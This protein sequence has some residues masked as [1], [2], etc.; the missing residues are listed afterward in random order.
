MAEAPESEPVPSASTE[1]EI[2]AAPPD[3]KNEEGPLPEKRRKLDKETSEKLEHRLGGILCC[4]VCLDLPPAAVYQCSNGHLMCAPCFT[5]LLAD[6]RLRDEAATCPNCRV[7]ISKTSASRNLAVEKT[8]SELPSE[9]KYC[10]QVFPRHSLQHHE[11]KICEDRQYK[12]SQVVVGAPRRS[13]G[14]LG[15]LAQGLYALAAALRPRGAAS[16]SAPPPLPPRRKRLTGCR[17]ASIGCGWRGP[18]HEARA[19]EAACAHPGK[20]AAEVVDVLAER[21]RAARDANAVYTQVLDLL[22][23]EKITINDL[24]LKPYRTEEF[25]HKLYYETSRFNAFGHQWVVK[26]FVNRNQRDPTQSTQREITYQLILKSKTLSPLHVQWVGLRGPYGEAGVR[27][28]VQQHVFADDGPE[29]PPQPL[30]L[31]DHAD[32]NRLLANKAIHFRSPPYSFAS[33]VLT[34]A[35]VRRRRA[36]GA[37]AAAAAARPRRHQ[38][39]A[40]QQGHTLQVPALQLRLRR[41]DSSTC[42]P[43]TGPRR[44]RSRCRCATTPT[45]TGCSPTRPYTSGPRL[46]ASPPPS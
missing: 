32:T 16:A 7:E 40:R 24:Q 34:A 39:A 37:A 33:A 2:T 31:R 46:T 30:P 5:H 23:Y 6:A 19:H 11:E 17:Y 28:R 9:C 20:S 13:W 1:S 22:S 18:A 25:V 41:P 43:T 12:F 26:A 29:A 8:V 4:A 38:Q 35:R 44:R 42:S 15:R 36:R 45:P 14:G 10:A 27:A 21:E 3:E